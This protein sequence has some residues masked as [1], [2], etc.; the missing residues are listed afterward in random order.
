MI[1]RPNFYAESGLDRMSQRRADAE[2]LAAR[3]SDPHSRLVPVWRAQ[4][5]FRATA[6]ADGFPAPLFPAVTALPS[7][8]NGE[9]NVVLL[10]VIEEVAHFAVDLSHV[11]D[12]AEACAQL[13]GGE[14]ADLRR[15]GALL[16]RRAGAMLAYARGILH[17][18]SRHRFCGVCGAAT[19]SAHAGHLRLCTRPECR[20]QHFPRT[21]PAVIM[22]V[23]DGER[24]LLGRQRIW[25]P[26]MHSTLAGF[27]EPGE[28]LEEAVARE[29]YEETGVRVTDVRYH[30]SQ[31]WPFPASIMLGFHAKATTTTIDVDRVELEDARWFT[32]EELL[33]CPENDSFRLPRRDSIARRL[34]ESW[35][36]RD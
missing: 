11:E 28:S 33:A 22:L 24:C 29:V 15:Y 1:R 2:W 36:G 19:E 12:P 26:G 13:G 34:V 10:G 8:L 6:G 17:W 7:L 32:R 9:R 31:P 5:L 23:T 27:V 14:F 18:H 16:E 35:L 25:A 21:D 3:L 30:S 20:A 4:N